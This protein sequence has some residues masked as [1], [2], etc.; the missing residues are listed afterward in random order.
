LTFVIFKPRKALVQPAAFFGCSIDNDT[1]QQRS[2]YKTPST[3]D[4]GNNV[5]WFNVAQE[6]SGK[7]RWVEIWT[8]HNC[9]CG[10]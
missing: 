8:C 10:M 3:M 5:H 7:S 4:H 2:Y 6:C 9:A 1:L